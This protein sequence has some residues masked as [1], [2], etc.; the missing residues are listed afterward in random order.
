MN[1]QQI[2]QVKEALEQLDP[3]EVARL[4][5]Q[6]HVYRIITSMYN[7][8][9]CDAAVLADD[10]FIYYEGNVPKELVR[11]VVDGVLP[12]VLHGTGLVFPDGKLTLEGVHIA[13]QHNKLFAQSESETKHTLH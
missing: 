12:F 7:T 8:Q 9:S 2:Q 3:M 10:I 5:L 13:K 11:E 4:Q 6:T 1:H